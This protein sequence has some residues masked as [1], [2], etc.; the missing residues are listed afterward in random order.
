M[1]GNNV[2]EQIRYKDAWIYDRHTYTKVETWVAKCGTLWK[3]IVTILLLAIEETAAANGATPSGVVHKWGFG[4]SIDPDFDRAP[5][6]VEG[7]IHI[8]LAR[9]GDTAAGLA[10]LGI[11]N[12]FGAQILHLFGN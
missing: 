11:R 7:T 1:N 8:G 10:V 12:T 9:E 4:C 6:A 2:L 3:F 5:K